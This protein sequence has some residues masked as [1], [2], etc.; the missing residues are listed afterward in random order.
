MI[1]GA[2]RSAAALALLASIAPAAA[3][4]ETR[5]GE[6]GEFDFYVLALSWSP[7]F[8]ATAEGAENR[9]TDEVERV[10]GRPPVDLAAFARATAAAWS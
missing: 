4:R 6:P 7:G 2:R 1:R 10:T 5:G 3:Q 8:C 9:V